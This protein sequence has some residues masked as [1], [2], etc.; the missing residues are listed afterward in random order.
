MTVHRTRHTVLT[1]A[2]LLIA[3]LT[4]AAPAA[5]A[6]TLHHVPH[7]IVLQRSGPDLQGLQVREPHGAM[8]PHVATAHS[9]VDPFADLH[10][11]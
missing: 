1:F 7:D 6:A 11:E 9:G 4:S 8:P 10:F 5:T 2:A 3:G